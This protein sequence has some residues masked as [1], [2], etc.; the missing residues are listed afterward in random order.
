MEVDSLYNDK[1]NEDFL[2][3]NAEILGTARNPDGLIEV[4]EKFNI[5]TSN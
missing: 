4:K 1:S 3:T 2:M 5:F